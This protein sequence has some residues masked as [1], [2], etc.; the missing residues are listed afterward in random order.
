M[1]HDENA[2]SPTALAWDRDGE[3]RSEDLEHLRIRLEA[4]KVSCQ[5]QGATV[6]SRR[7]SHRLVPHPPLCQPLLLGGVQ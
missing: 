7:R 1:D 2:L 5:R 3:L 4:Q 6:H